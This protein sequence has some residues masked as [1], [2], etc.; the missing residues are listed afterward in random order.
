MKKI[1]NIVLKLLLSLLLVMP[2][3]GAAGI[4]PAPTP[5]MYN[6]PEAYDFIA[7]LMAGKYIMIIQAIVFALVVLCL[8]TKRVALAALLIL[9]IT[10]NIVGFHL[11]LDGGLFTPGAVMAN[12]F[13]V[14][15]LYFLWQERK[16][17]RSL[18][19]AEKKS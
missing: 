14:L 18:L 13:L 11:F 4:F 8:W 2:I 19:K 7:M 3:L 5:E 1:F 6:T 16:E 12:V 17:Y 9:P 15:N 10:V